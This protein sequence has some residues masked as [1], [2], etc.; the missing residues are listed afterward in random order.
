MFKLIIMDNERVQSC[1]TKLNPLAVQYFTQ[2]HSVI[3][4][5]QWKLEQ[6]EGKKDSHLITPIPALTL[7]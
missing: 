5:V 6:V 1:K 7:V 3:T 2:F 4:N